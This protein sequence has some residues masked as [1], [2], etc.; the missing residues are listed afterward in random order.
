M[1]EE[2]KIVVVG[3]PRVGKT[4]LLMAISS[5]RFADEYIPTVFENFEQPVLVDG[6]LAKITWWDTAGQDQYKN[7]RPLIYPGTTLFLICVSVDS[8]ES[9]ALIKSK[10][11]PELVRNCP[12]ALH[13]IVGTKI[14]LRNENS[15]LITEEEGAALAAN[16]GV[17][18]YMECSAKKMAGVREVVERSVV[19]LRKYANS[20]IVNKDGTV[21]IVLP[22]PQMKSAAK[23]DISD[24]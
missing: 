21:D 24:N 4:S 5:G 14:D 17:D 16:A 12:A 1:E 7:L 18:L 19:H 22:Q 9:T 11:I 8:G 13:V 3:E 2:W 23:S 6:V 10:W 20:R 15:S